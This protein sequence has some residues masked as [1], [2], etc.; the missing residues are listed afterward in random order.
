MAEVGMQAPTKR[1]CQREG[2]P[3]YIPS[4]RNGRRVSSK[5]KFHSKEC[6]QKAAGI[7]TLRHDALKAELARVA[8]TR[9]E[10]VLVNCARGRS[11]ELGRAK[12]P[13]D[14]NSVRGPVESGKICSVEVE[15]K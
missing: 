13:Q 12:G 8:R 3:H 10:P 14:R 7:A 9:T 2:C 5:T 6:K 15:E 1:K 11:V 4:W